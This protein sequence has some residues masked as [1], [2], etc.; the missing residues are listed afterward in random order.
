M[1]QKFTRKLITENGYEFCGDAFGADRETVCELVFCTSMVGY[2]ELITDPACAD[3]GVVMTYPLIGSYGMNDEDNEAR[4]PLIRGLIV[5]E[6]NDNPSNFRYTRTLG[7]VMEDN[8]IAGIAGV[9]T[10]RLTRMLRG[11]GTQRAILTGPKTTLEEGVARIRATPI[12]TDAVARVSCKKLWYARTPNFRY[13]VVAIDCGIKNSAVRMLGARGCNVTVVPYD[14]GVE[15]ILRLRPDG[16]FVSGGPGDPRN[17]MPVVQTLRALRG[18]LPVFGTGLG[19]L[20]LCL[21][22][23]AQTDRMRLGHVGGNHPV[24]NLETGKIEITS[25]NHTY[26]VRGESLAAAGLRATHADILDG[27]V[28]GVAAEDG[29]LFSV[30][31][32][33]ESAPGPKDGSELFD[34]FIALLQKGGA[35]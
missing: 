33:P 11:E 22:C 29:S 12:P 10:R 23:G 16:L 1:G 31:F 4:T 30:Q 3:L 8:G 13:N 6:Y 24:R 2:Q 14:T 34:Q 18:K 17:A 7:E 9:D 26:A 15:E 25:Q 35:R 21:A 20:L 5:R 28:E 32:S 27:T 19:H